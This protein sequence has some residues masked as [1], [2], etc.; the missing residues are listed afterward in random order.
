MLSQYELKSLA[1]Q[2]NPNCSDTPLQLTAP[3]PGK[4]GLL[5]LK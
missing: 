4:N 1:D 3:L 2:L 5:L